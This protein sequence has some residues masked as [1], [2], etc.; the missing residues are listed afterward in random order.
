MSDWLTEGQLERRT[1]SSKALHVLWPSRGKHE[2]LT[3]GPNLADDFMDL[4]FETHVEHTVCLVE[5]DVGDPAKVRLFG[6]PTCRR[7][8]PAWQS[9]PQHRARDR[10]SVVP[11]VHRHRPQYCE[12]ASLN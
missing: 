3:I 5:N 9:Q 6:I 8:D 7:G 2:R 10:E 1:Y 11:R 4:G 12:Y